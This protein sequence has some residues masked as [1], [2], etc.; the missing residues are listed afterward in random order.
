MLDEEA[1]DAFGARMGFQYGS[2]VAAVPGS[3]PP[4][5][6]SAAWNQEPLSPDP[7]GFGGQWGYQKNAA[8]MLGGPG[9]GSVSGYLLGHRLYDASTGRFL[10]RDPIGYNGGVNL[11][12]FAGNNPVNETDPSSLS[13]PDPIFDHFSPKPWYQKAADWFSWFYHRG[14]RVIS[15]TPH[16]PFTLPV[17][18]VGPTASGGLKRGP[19]SWPSGRHNQVIQ[20]GIGELEKQGMTHE[21]GG[22][23]TEEWIDTRGGFK[24]NRR[25]DI[26]MK[27]PDG[28]FYRE[29][30]GRTM[31][32]GSPV[33]RE[34]KALDDIEKAT[35]Q[36]PGFTPYDR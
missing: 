6:V 3:N 11:Y 32:D 35:G 4:Y 16:N 30:V 15:D 24:P 14:D 36:R 34:K 7:V 8:G 19:N 28:T 26:T 17:G 2:T 27:R 31:K 12:G 5:A 1:Y 29:Q 9:P 18:G 22:S 23:K 33:P 13:V 25:V 10:T 21:A 20:R